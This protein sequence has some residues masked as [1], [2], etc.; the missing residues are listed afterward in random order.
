MGS[1]AK[2]PVIADLLEVCLGALAGLIA[3]LAIVTGH[4][5]QPDPIRLAF[6]TLFVLFSSRFVVR[7]DRGSLRLTM[8]ATA[9]S[10]LLLS[11]PWAALLGAIAGLTWIGHAPP[12]RRSVGLGASI[13]WACSG[14]AIQTFASPEP[15]SVR[16]IGI[17]TVVVIWMILLNWIHTPIAIW[18]ITG[19]DPRAVFRRAWGRSF[20]NTFGY[21]GFGAILV[22]SVLD[23]TPRGYLLASF[24][25]ILTVSLSQALA[26]GRSAEALQTQVDDG[27]RHLAYRRA[28]EGSVHNF[29]NELAVVKG[30]LEAVSDGRLSKLTRGRVS[31]A[32]EALDNVLRRLDGFLRLEC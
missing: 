7:L 11:P 17:A 14:S 10:A 26:S 15:G 13:F 25:G 20:L 23:G 31:D 18:L 22:A 28:L 9:A 27:L 30:N 29:R 4:S 19:E 16:A 3:I 24:V 2:R 12:A 8:V 21:F 5:V 6:L 32:S 1:G